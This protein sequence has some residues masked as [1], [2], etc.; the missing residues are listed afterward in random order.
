MRSLPATPRTTASAASTARNWYVL[1]V[2][3]VAAVLSYTDRLILNVLVEPLKRDLHLSDTQISL[4]QGAAFAV[5]YSLAALPLGRLADIVN[6]R[7]M[8]IG[9]I[10]LWSLGTALCGAAHSFN[11]LFCARLMVGLGEA[12]LF[13]TGTSLLLGYFPARQRGTAIGVFF[14]GASVGGGACVLVGGMLLELFSTRSAALGL[15][16]LDPWR[17]VLVSLAIPGLLLAALLATIR[18]PPRGVEAGP[19]AGTARILEG[20][21]PLWQRRH[22]VGLLIIAMMFQA[23]ADYGSSAWLP[24]LL[25]RNFGLPP[26]QAAVRLGPAILVAAIVGPSA[27]GMLADFLHAHDRVAWKL[28]VSAAMLLAGAPLGY[29]CFAPSP[30]LTIVL[31]GALTAVMG[32]SVLIATACVQ[33]VIADGAR[34]T[35]IAVQSFVMTIVGLGC[36]PT[37]VALINDGRIG[38]SHGIGA[39]IA[40]VMVPC[41]VCGAACIFA[42]RATY[43]RAVVQ[44]AGDPGAQVH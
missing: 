9:G 8:L 4:L 44:P 21:D 7:N 22:L 38:H 42:A 37:A 24:S 40:S 20:L 25:V 33:D 27:G 39:S 11:Q 23:I 36:G 29:L 28:P 15:G 41:L 34:G 14:M 30:W 1:A 13:P 5:I 10:V 32:I 31:Y 12:G 35:I 3:F 17:C 18:E 19:A 2:L 6:R 26:A 43:R 16:A